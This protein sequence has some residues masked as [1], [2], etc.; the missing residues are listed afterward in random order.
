[1]GLEAQERADGLAVSGKEYVW[2][3]WHQRQVQTVLA[4][5]PADGW[6]RLSAGAG[7]QGPRWYAWYGLPW[8]AP[9]LPAWRRWLLVR[10]SVSA[11]TER[12]AFVVFSPQATPLAEVVQTA[13]TRWTIER[14]FAAAKGAVGLDQDEVR[15]WTGWQ[16][17]IT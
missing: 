5:L 2:L 10:R 15:R 16:R 17:H 13:G 1:M 4:A 9:M 7:A 8:A 11:P 12:T 6:T 14:G 3:G